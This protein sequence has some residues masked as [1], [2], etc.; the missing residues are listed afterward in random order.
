MHFRVSK[1]NWNAINTRVVHY[2]VSTFNNATLEYVVKFNPIPAIRADI[3]RRM[4]IGWTCMRGIKWWV[5]LWSYTQEIPAM[6][7]PER[8]HTHTHIPHSIVRELI[9]NL[10]GTIVDEDEDGNTPLHQACINGHIGV[11]KVLVE[12][13]ADVEARCVHVCVCVVG[14]CGWVCV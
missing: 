10:R 13:D 9:R 3:A 7:I 8:S 4:W 5:G 2:V 14:V 1:A 6:Y 12:A 11:A